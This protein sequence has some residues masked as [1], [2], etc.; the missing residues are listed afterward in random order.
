MTASI[1]R[2]AHTDDAQAVLKLFKLLDHE[3]TFMLF[4]PGERKTTL[5]QQVQKIESFR[6][7]S[8]SELLVADINGDIVGLVGA[9]GGK[10]NRNKHS[11]SLAIG[12]AKE[13]GGLGIGTKL[14]TAI[15]SWAKEN[16][17]HRL[18]LTVMSHN[19]V[20]QNL[21]LKFGYRQEG[22]KTHSLKVQGEYVDEWLMAKLI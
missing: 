3:S 7:E 13:F 5:E 6:S 20:A 19:I 1:I 2:P 21:Y 15:E 11:L 8:Q 16:D 12:V 14:M 9:H 4:E 17:F 18:E 22:V 10:A